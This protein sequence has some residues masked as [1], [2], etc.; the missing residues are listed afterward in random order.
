[1]PSVNLISNIGFNQGEAT[2]TKRV[3]KFSNM[4]TSELT[5]PLKA[6]ESIIRSVASDKIVR[7]NNYPFLRFFVGRFIKKHLKK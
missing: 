2:H 6:P 7:E 3:G 4:T 1:M 5:F